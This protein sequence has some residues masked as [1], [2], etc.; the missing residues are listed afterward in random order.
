MK[1]PVLGGAYMS[2]SANLA[3]QRCIN[4]Y[5]ELVETKD[6]KAVGGFYSVPGETL[7]ASVGTGPHRGSR[8]RPGGLLYVVSGSG[9]YSVA[10]STWA[11]T[12]LGN[13]GTSTGPV[14]IIDNGTQI[15]VFDG[16]AGY[17]WTGT[18]FV[19]ISLPAT[20]PVSAN[21]QDGFGLVNQ[22]G[23]QTW[24]QSNYKDLT[25]WN[26][27]NF[28]TKDAKPDWVVAI[29]DKN[30][31]V[32]LFGQ[33]YTEVWVN[34]GVSGFTFQRLQGVFLQAGCCATFSVANIEESL[35]WLGS[36]EYGQGVVLVSEGYRAKRVSTHAIEYAIK[37]YVAAG[38]T[39]SDAIG[40]VYQDAGH[41]FYVL[42]F[43]SA[44]VTWTWDMVTGLWH[45]RAAFVNGAFNR[46]DGT[47]YAFYGGRHVIGDWQSSNLYALDLEVYTDNG[48]PRKWLRS[49][50]ALPPNK[51][52]TEPVTFDSLQLDLETGMTVPA[53]TNPQIAL[54]WSDDGGNSW[55]NEHLE[56]WG[57]TGATANR[58]KWR[59]LG[60][61]REST[62]LDRT[63]EISSSDPVRAALIGADMEAQ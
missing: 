49:W 29:G 19:A 22:L 31:E 7:L 25:T 32:W 15:A 24:W 56:A 33:E 5:P 36:N 8:A 60:Q 43:P 28:G 20:G 53:G 12:L 21:Y 57:V 11:S 58:V 59:R 10:A 37:G 39:I 23:T 42:T 6:G 52:S 54:R 61:T 47:S 34:A 9:L 40:Y 35:I 41:T 4:L 2:R 30:R 27:L 13:L 55:S 1:T 62:G 3:N 18:A 45:E 44:N 50:R 14:C 51:A 17:C 46:H 38:L 48:R 26:A 63:F 16:V